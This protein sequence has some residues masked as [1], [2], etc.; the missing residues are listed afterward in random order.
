M[1]SIGWLVLKECIDCFYFD[2]I[3]LGFYSRSKEFVMN[4]GSCSGDC[5]I[6]LLKLLEVYMNFYVVIIYFGV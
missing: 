1:R 4:F 3:C 5:G 2:V 6:Y